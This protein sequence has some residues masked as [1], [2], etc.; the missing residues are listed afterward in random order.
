[1]MGVR[2]DIKQDKLYPCFCQAC[3][4]G[5][6]ESAMSSKD[7]RYCVDCQQV[8]EAEYALIADNSGRKSRYVPVAHIERDTSKEEEVLLHTNNENTHV[9]QNPTQTPIINLGGRPRKDIPTDLIHKLSKQD[10]SIKSIVQE[11]KGRGY[12][13]SAM[14]VSRVLLGKRGG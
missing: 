13:L 10:L 8:I 6:T 12:T 3:L 14:T 7:I 11:L 2:F 9:Y 1:M 4:V 5:K